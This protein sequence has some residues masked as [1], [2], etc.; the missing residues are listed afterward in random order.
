MGKKG[1]PASRQR[2]RLKEGGTP[3]QKFKKIPIFP[4]K[5]YTSRLALLPGGDAG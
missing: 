2:V 3:W 4:M 5:G 1:R